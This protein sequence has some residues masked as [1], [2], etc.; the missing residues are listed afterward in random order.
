MNR[1]LF[2][3]LLSALAYGCSDSRRGG[4]PPPG[5]PDEPKQAQRDAE[6]LGREVFDLV[7]QAMSYK[8]SHQG[9]LPV[10]FRQMGLDTLTPLTVRRLAATGGVPTVTVLF[11]KTAGRGVKSCR[12]S[13]QVVEDA[14]LGGNRFA[15]TCVRASGIADVF[16]VEGK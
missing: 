11:R 12:G 7:D 2:L 8:G 16:N 15:I 5:D 13:S 14:M 4:A 10:S 3:F 1:Q 6:Y 9:R